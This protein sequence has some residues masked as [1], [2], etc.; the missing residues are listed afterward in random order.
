MNRKQGAYL[1][2][3]GIL[4]YFDI[5]GF[6]VAVGCGYDSVERLELV[7]T[8]QEFTEVDKVGGALEAGIAL[9]LGFNAF[10]YGRARLAL[11]SQNV[12]DKKA[13]PLEHAER[14]FIDDRKGLE[15]LLDKTAAH[16]RNEWGTL[17]KVY[18]DRGRAIIY[19]ILDPLVAKEKG[20]IG[21]GTRTALPFNFQRADEAGY[22]GCHHYHPNFTGP[23]WLEASNFT[24]S[25]FD[26]TQTKNWINLLTFNMPDGP[27]IIGFNR[28]YTY[29]PV[30]ASKRK[31]AQAT[32]KQIM[33]Y[34]RA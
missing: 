13:Y 19:D 27:E 26:K 22:K 31:L 32:P 16:K 9:S 30:D 24:I 21:E 7:I 17:L 2:G 6:A 5:F 15:F 1:C 33:E 11:H 8:A 12:K 23:E 28:Q 25:F 29:L 34:L 4:N 14:I 20:L 18:P 3:K 10:N